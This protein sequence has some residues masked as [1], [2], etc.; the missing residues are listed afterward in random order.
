M[1]LSFCSMTWVTVSCT[2]WAEAPGYTAL[3]A[4]WGGAIGGYWE[5]G[6]FLIARRPASMT[7]MA[8]TQAKIGLFMKKRDME[9][10]LDYSC[11]S[12]YRSCKS[13]RSYMTYVTCYFF[14]AAACGAPA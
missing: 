11:D 13:Y 3:M 2:V 1:P 12:S 8:V 6:S 14:A 9:R 5:T 4:I 10:L 7:M